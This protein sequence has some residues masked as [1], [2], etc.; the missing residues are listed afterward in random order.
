MYVHLYDAS[1]LDWHLE[2]GT[3][4]KIR[5]ETEYPWEGAVKLT[6]S[7]A[8]AKEF[9]VFLRN[10]GWSQKTVVRVNGQPMDSGQPG[11]YLPLRREWKPGDTIDVV[12]DMA[13]QMIHA[14]P[15]V[16]ED[17][18]KLAFQRGAVVFCMEGLDRKVRTTQVN[19]SG[20]AAHPTGETTARY[21]PALLDGVVVLEH[22]GML[23][24]AAEGEAL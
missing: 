5:Q 14:N 6:V 15:A 20:Y 4:L 7:P 22:T 23:P 19:L 10:P 11:H 12:F 24:A 13:P 16:R 17:V 18:G 21:D 2:D 9:T 1:T 3:G 8:T